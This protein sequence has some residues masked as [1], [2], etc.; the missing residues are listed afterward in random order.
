[1]KSVFHGVCVAFL[2]LILAGCASHPR[3]VDCEGHLRPINPPA[4]ASASTAV[5][6]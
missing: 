3:R 4:P 2:V 1:M 5:R 6:P